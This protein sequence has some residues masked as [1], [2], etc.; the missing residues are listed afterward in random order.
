MGKIW[1]YSTYG[2]FTRQHRNF[3]YFFSDSVGRKN[4]F[5]II[6]NTQNKLIAF[7]PIIRTFEK[8]PAPLLSQSSAK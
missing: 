5:L 7:F 6:F 1:V 8:I 4:N 3:S 2:Q